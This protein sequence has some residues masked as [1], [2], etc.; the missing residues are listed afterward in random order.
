MGII[1]INSKDPTKLPEGPSVYDSIRDLMQYP[2][3]VSADAFRVSVTDTISPSMFPFRMSFDRLITH[4]DHPTYRLCP[5]FSEI[6]IDKDGNILGSD[7][8]TSFRTDGGKEYVLTHVPGMYKSAFVSKFRLYADAWAILYERRATRIYPV[9]RNGNWMDYSPGNVK[10]TDATYRA[11]NSRWPEERYK[12]ERIDPDS[13]VSID[14]VDMADMLSYMESRNRSSRRLGG[15][16]C[17]TPQLA[18]IR[19]CPPAHNFDYCHDYFWLQVVYDEST[20]AVRTFADRS[21]LKHF[22]LREGYVVSNQLLRH[23]HRTG[24]SCLLSKDRP[25]E[26]VDSWSRFTMF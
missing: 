18:H 10:W 11:Y 26:F 1:Y 19:T 4:P 13:L 22:L 8:M 3:H 17:V 6:Y 14:Y 12:Y 7:A 16:E 5:N 9:P 25:A 20:N 23:I 24:K 2:D 15:I 21:G